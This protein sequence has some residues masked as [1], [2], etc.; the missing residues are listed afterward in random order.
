MKKVIA[1]MALIAFGVTPAFAG[2][3]IKITFADRTDEALYP[4][5]GKSGSASAKS[6]Q[7]K[8]PPNLKTGTLLIDG[9]RLK[10]TS[11]DNPDTFVV[12]D[13]EKQSYAVG[14]LQEPE[15]EHDEKTKGKPQK[16]AIVGTLD[17]FLQ[18]M[19]QLFEM[20]KMFMPQMKD[21]MKKPA[22][23]DPATK[24]DYTVTPGLGEMEV[25]GCKTTGVRVTEI[26][27][28]ISQSQTEKKTELTGKTRSVR[29]LYSCPEVDIA[30]LIPY[31]ENIGKKIANWA[32]KWDELF[33]EMTGGTESGE[34]QPNLMTV[35]FEAR[36]VSD[37]ISVWRSLKGFPFLGRQIETEGENKT[38][39]WFRVVSYRS[40]EVPASEFAVP[41]GYRVQKL[42]EAISEMMGGMM[43]SGMRQGAS[44]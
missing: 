14:F 12:V 28:A 44:G 41:K 6:T 29:E 26:Q 1:V 33:G 20:L 24:I 9:S 19:D 10:W 5:E 2:W 35:P 30:Y 3:E 22:P 13:L 37:A 31:I 18:L 23:P 17:E 11:E 36:K 25:A 15:A 8:T 16:V 34:G 40:R 38:T 7:K 27:T 32:K 43:G 21:Q 39:E 42:E 4:S